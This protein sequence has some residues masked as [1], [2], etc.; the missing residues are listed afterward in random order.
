[1]REKVFLVFLICSLEF[2]NYNF[3]LAFAQGQENQQVL[4]VTQST[5]KAP[6]QEAVAPLEEYVIAIDDSIEVFVWQN[7]DL[8][9]DVIVGPD[10][11]ISYPLVGRIQAAG[12]TIKQLEEKIKEALSK[13]IRYPEVSIMIKKFSGDKII[14]LGGV[15]SPGIHTY[16]GKINLIEAIAMAGD[17]AEDA[18]KDYVMIVRGDLV[19]HPE[20]T[21]VNLQ[22]FMKG[23][24]IKTGIILKPNDVVFV[25]RST[26][27][28]DN[29]I[30]LGEVGGP[31]VYK[32]H[33]GINLIEAI[34]LAG[35]FGGDARKDSVMIVRGY[36][37]EHPAVT[38]VN[39]QQII[40]GKASKTSILLQPNDVIYVPKSFISNINKFLSNIRPTIDHAM[41]MFNFRS[42]IFR[43]HRKGWR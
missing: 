13:Y 20:V 12:L 28:G 37:T 1:M 8:S 19:E 33:D 40:W 30:V 16:K 38:R 24:P 25:P 42:E 4:N 5:E 31:G 17:F 21:I 39:A 2:I 11:N 26:L 23:E 18:R 32:Y 27:A 22:R 6:P 3:P 15:G 35:D 9:K 36:L 43:L 14:I 41:A 29:I 10:G 7:P 34:A